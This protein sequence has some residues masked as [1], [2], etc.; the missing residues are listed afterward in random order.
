MLTYIE[1]VI[2]CQYLKS[3]KASGT[4]N[5][6]NAYANETLGSLA[7]PLELFQ[8]VIT[9]SLETIML[10]H[11][12]LNWILIESNDLNKYEEKFEHGI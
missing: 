12:F 7:Y 10:V 6:A 5:D 8:R 9:V 1:S 11:S 4:V 3:D 2:E